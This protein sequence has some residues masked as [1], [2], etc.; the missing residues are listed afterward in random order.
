LINC[1]LAK[2]LK[3]EANGMR[4]GDVYFFTAKKNKKKKRK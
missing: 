4:L 3:L 2:F 1:V